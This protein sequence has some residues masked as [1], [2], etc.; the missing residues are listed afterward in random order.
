ML[1]SDLFLCLANL[2]SIRHHELSHR[3][4]KLFSATSLLCDLHRQCVEFIYTTRND[5]EV[6][7]YGAFTLAE[8]STEANNRGITYVVHTNYT[9][10]HG[11]P[12]FN[13][14]MAEFTAWLM[15]I[16]IV[17]LPDTDQIFKGNALGATIALF[18]LFS[19]GI[20]SFTYL[21]CFFLTKST[22]AQIVVLFIT[23]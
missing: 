21:Q 8:I 13:A 22:S 9:A 10:V 3:Q 17:S 4:G 2:Q 15:I 11:G 7:R 1:G 19:L 18:L 20:T 16:I 5:Y 14:L 23:S 6:S 12:L